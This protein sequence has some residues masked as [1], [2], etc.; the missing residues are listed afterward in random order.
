[1]LKVTKTKLAIASKILI[2]GIWFV[3]LLT[4]NF[5]VT[6]AIMPFFDIFCALLLVL[7]FAVNSYR[8]K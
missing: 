1:M 8:I 6:Y 3:Q 5:G 2:F 4:E 7:V